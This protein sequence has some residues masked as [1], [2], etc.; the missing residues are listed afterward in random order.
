MFQEIISERPHLA[1]LEDEEIGKELVTR[2][3]L[4]TDSIDTS[5]ESNLKAI[6]QFVEK[7]ENDLF[8][9]DQDSIAVQ[10]GF[11][12]FMRV[13]INEFIRHFNNNTND[14]HSLFNFVA[15]TLGDE[16]EGLYWGQW[17]SS[18]YAFAAFRVICLDPE[19]FEIAFNYL[20]S[21]P[22]LTKK[23]MEDMLNT[24][25]LRKKN[26]YIPSQPI[27]EQISSAQDIFELARTFGVN[28]AYS[29]EPGIGFDGRQNWW[30]RSIERR[31]E[32]FAMD[33][34]AIEN[35]DPDIVVD[36]VNRVREIRPIFNERVS[37]TTTN[38]WNVMSSLYNLEGT[39]PFINFMTSKV[40]AKQ[41]SDPIYIGEHQST[42]FAF[43]SL[44]VGPDMIEDFLRDLSIQ[45]IKYKDTN[46]SNALKKVIR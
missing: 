10:M 31:L 3:N 45:D 41:N 26:S 33:Q 29:R 19:E 7:I 28:E 34:E 13:E 25:Y 14:I 8:E 35:L 30:V 21:Y 38:V 12:S 11:P 6:H 43:I 42:F 32:L 16:F 24:L 37:F 5:K 17:K 2:I 15:K 18:L 44:L 23:Y 9:G 46:I 22:N 39:K 1:E 36:L 27:I 40:I 20:T 4:L